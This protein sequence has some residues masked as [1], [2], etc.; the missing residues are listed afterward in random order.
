MILQKSDWRW[1]EGRRLLQFF[2]P[3]AGPVV[4]VVEVH[5]SWVHAAI[6][7]QASGGEDAFAC[8][9][10][11]DVAADGDVV[12]IDRGLVETGTGIG[13]HPGFELGVAG[14]R[15]LDEAE[16]LLAV[17]A[18]GVEHHLVVALATGGVVGMQLACGFEGAL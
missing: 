16:E 3:E 11:V 5:G 10:A 2:A 14:A 12:F 15:G 13:F 8:V 6:V 7:G 4:E 18:D 1:Y 9:V 17:D